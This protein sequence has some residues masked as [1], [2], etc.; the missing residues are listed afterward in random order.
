MALKSY[1]STLLKNIFCQ[2]LYIVQGMTSD[3]NVY[4]CACVQNFTIS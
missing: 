3:V 1:V 4:I 2:W